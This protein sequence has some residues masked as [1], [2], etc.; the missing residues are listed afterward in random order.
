VYL[1]QGKAGCIWDILQLKLSPKQQ[2]ILI[3]DVSEDS[4]EGSCSSNGNEKSVYTQI[5][6][7]D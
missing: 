1:Y 3:S 2:D 5:A 4:S 7:I 6:M